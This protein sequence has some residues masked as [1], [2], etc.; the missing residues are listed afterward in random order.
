M[1][2]GRHWDFEIWDLDLDISLELDSW[3]MDI[4]LALLPLIYP[5]RND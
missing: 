3:I 5:N 2:H 4:F 1:M